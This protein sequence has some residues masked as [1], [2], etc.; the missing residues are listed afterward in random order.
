ME[1]PVASERKSG[2]WNEA[3]GPLF[4]LG[5]IVSVGGSASARFF[6]NTGGLDGPVGVGLIV[7]A[8]VAFFVLTLF[9]MGWA[10]RKGWKAADKG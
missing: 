10:L 3:A 9:V 4:G 6:R 1:G 7:I 8:V 5:I 2:F